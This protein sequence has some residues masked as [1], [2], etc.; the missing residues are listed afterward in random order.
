M[1]GIICFRKCISKFLVIVLCLNC[2]GSN[3]NADCSI[4][5]QS[6]KIRKEWEAF[7]SLNGPK[8]ALSVVEKNFAQFYNNT[9]YYKELLI[10]LYCKMQATQEPDSF[11]GDLYNIVSCLNVCYFPDAIV[12]LL[13]R[14]TS[15]KDQRRLY[16]KYLSM[17]LPISIWQMEQGAYGVEV[18]ELVDPSADFAP[19]INGSIM[20]EVAR[21]F[22]EA[23]EWDLAW[24]AYVEGI[25]C[26]FTVP[27]S[28]NDRGTWHSDETAKYWLK[29]AECAHKANNKKLAENYLFKAAFFGDNSI[30][31]KVDKLYEGVNNN[32][33]QSVL[34][35]HDL[36]IDNKR[37]ALEEVVFLYA[38]I[39]VHPR[40]LQL[41]YDYKD[42]FPNAEEIRKRIEDEWIEISKNS[43]RGLSKGILYGVE[44]YPA[45]NDP[46]KI[47]VPWAFSDEAVESV[48]KRLREYSMKQK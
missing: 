7:Q 43:S 5:G 42:L 28:W 44:V 11:S 9:D 12:V 46:L 33:Q 30:S 27:F 19:L 25:C 3:E 2:V 24:R 45:K 16:S 38:K 41:L 34:V 37:K 6:K 21:K 10:F 36:S 40:A 47:R 8:I 26:E 29:V 22:E 32:H 31:N 23:E 35:P 15:R 39:N 13:E 17:L 48:R 14:S 18:L 20:L 4:Y 1:S